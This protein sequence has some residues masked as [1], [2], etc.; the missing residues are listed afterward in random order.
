MHAGERHGGAS[1]GEAR[2]EAAGVF[3]V[4]FESAQVAVV[5]SADEIFPVVS[6]A[7]EER[8]GR[9]ER[10]EVILAENLDDRL[11]GVAPALRDETRKFVGRQEA[12]DEE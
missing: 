6:G 10:F 9:G 7:F 3:Q 11:D 2:R 1:G 12:R 5:Y 8:G 4:D